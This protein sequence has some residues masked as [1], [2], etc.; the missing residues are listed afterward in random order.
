MIEIDADASV[1]RWIAE[2][3]EGEASAAQRLWE[4]YFHRLVGLARAKLTASPRRLADEEDVALSAFKSFCLGVADGR[5]P[6]LRDRDNLWPLL[7]VLTVR[8]AQDLVKHE[9]RQKRGGGSP[10]GPLGSDGA[11]W[12]AITSH[13][14]T[15]E[16]AAMVAE[17]CDR[18]LAMLDEPLRQIAL[19]KLEA[20]T[21]AE[22]AARLDC[23]L[24][25]IE[26][27][28]ELIRRTWQGA[29]IVK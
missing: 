11:E 15:P 13:E 20:Y 10:A 12:E 18:L 26:R 14:P 5:F 19:L 17:N 24:R 2:L 8:K 16:F 4:Q 28:L 25:T 9:R 3:K 29:E 7:V 21:S 6:Q 1:T 27:R 22:I 23:G